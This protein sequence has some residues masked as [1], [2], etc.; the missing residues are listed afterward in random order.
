MS[1]AQQL[2]QT[3]PSRACARAGDQ[4]AQQLTG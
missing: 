2:A 1:Y 3:I 4:L